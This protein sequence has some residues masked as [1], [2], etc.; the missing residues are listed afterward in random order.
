MC[1]QGPSQEVLQLVLGVYEFREKIKQS[2]FEV[3]F[4]NKYHKDPPP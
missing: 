1:P 3:I 4:G 2:K